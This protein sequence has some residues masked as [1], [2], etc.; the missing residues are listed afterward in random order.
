MKRESAIFR[1]L[2]YVIKPNPGMSFQHF[3]RV[4]YKRTVT[5]MKEA[6]PVRMRALHHFLKEKSFSKMILPAV[7]FFCNVETRFRLVTHV[8]L[9]LEEIIPYGF[10]EESLP[11]S[12][13]GLFE[14]NPN[15]VNGE[16][17]TGTAD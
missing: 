9:P 16:F 5:A 11:V 6:Y 10:T 3:D 1:G 4:F 13:G 2:V 15:W 8:R 7:K 14:T 17:E 12:L